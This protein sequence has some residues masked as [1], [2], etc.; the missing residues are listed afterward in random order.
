M[1]HP[2]KKIQTSKISSSFDV[3]AHIIVIA[4]RIG[5]SFDELNE[6]SVQELLDIANTYSGESEKSQ[7]K[8]EA[9]Q[10]DI[11]RFTGYRPK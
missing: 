4:K 1:L 5:L 6:L 3:G 10:A 11:D 2:R 9:T 8:R 7:E